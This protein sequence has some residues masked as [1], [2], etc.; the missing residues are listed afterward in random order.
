MPNPKIDVVIIGAGLSGLMAATELHRA[1]LSY[2]VLEAMDRVGGKTLTV[3]ASSQGGHVDVGAAWINDTNQSCMYALA[4]KFG[5]DLKV[6]R[7]EGNAIFEDA[8][9]KLHEIKYGEVGVWVC[10]AFVMNI[11]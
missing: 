4:Q 2:V 11:W 9:G 1:G 6:Q 8:N 10:T 7:A 5:F 3:A